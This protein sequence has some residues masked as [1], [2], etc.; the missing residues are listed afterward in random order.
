MRRKYQVAVCICCLQVCQPCGNVLFTEGNKSAEKPFPEYLLPIQE[1]DC[2]VSP[3][4]K[5]IQSFGA[6]IIFLILPHPVYKM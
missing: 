3:T 1:F 4:G 2:P 6:G 5:R